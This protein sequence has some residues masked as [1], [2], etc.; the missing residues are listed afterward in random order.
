MKANLLF[1]N[2]D[3]SQSTDFFNGQNSNGAAAAGFKEDNAAEPKTLYVGNLDP[4]V[5]EDFITT[6]FTQIGP[7]AKCKIIWENNAQEPYAFVEFGDHT[8]ANQALNI[9]NKRVLLGKEM[10]VNWA[11]QPGVATSGGVGGVPASADYD[12]PGPKVDTSKHFHIFV[13]DLSPEV[14]NKALREAFQPFGEISEAKV[15]R[16]LQTMK[17]KGY[18]FVAYP[19][20]EDAER[21]IEQMNGAW[22]G[23]RA[24]RT[25]WATRRGAAAQPRTL[26]YDEVYNQTHPSN[27]TVYV[28][29]LPQN[30]AE[31]ELRR[32]FKQ[33]G[34][35]IEI[36]LFKTQGYSFVRY[37]TKDS[38]CQA[39]IN[40]NNVDLDGHQLRCS[41]GRASDV[42]DNQ[43]PQQGG[44]GAQGGYG[45]GYGYGQAGNAGF[46]GPQANA[47]NMAAQQ[48]AQQY[49]NQYY[50]YYNNPALMQQWQSYWQQQGGQ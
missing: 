27:T 13:G 32:L 38:A 48:Q 12:E 11:T 28:G 31:D 41:W 22:L 33:F 16:D 9:M 5:T 17:S 49:W 6:L 19:N 39:I 20:K 43:G 7:V 23:R 26:S 37:D 36:R 2:F 50:Q 44:P 42:S 45:Y 30:A 15:I 35:I 47:A 40:N 24:I 25:N 4:S 21:A 8:T 14:D 34:N 18:G 46:G 29:N 10:K 1:Q 3:P